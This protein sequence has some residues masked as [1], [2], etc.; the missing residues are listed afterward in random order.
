MYA[1]SHDSYTTFVDFFDK[2]V[3]AYHGVKM[4]A[5]EA[6]M[7]AGNLNAPHFPPEDAKMIV[8]TRIRVGRNLKDYPLGPGIT[9]AQRTEME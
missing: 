5:I 9:N 8:S 7:S 3:E 6:T 1:G 4:H 2:I